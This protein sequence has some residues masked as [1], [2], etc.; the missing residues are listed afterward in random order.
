MSPSPSLL[1]LPPSVHELSL[2]LSASLLGRSS[3][4]LG[5]SASFARFD[6]G[7]AAVSGEGTRAS[8]ARSVGVRGFR[9]D[10]K[11]VV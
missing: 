9:R 8:E 10:R 5:G 3:S 2:S 11:S 4:S 1:E 7:M 6:G